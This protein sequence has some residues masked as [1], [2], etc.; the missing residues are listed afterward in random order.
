MPASVLH[1]SCV[2]WRGTG[3]LILGRSGSGKSALALQLIAFG[4]TLVSDDRVQV[5]AKNGT[6]V[7][8]APAQ[9]KG[10][11]EAR[12]VGILRADTVAQTTLTLAVDLDQHAPDRLPDAHVFEL[13]D[14][15]LPCL[16]RVDAPH[17][18]AAVFQAL[19]GGRQEPG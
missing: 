4:A 3:V 16:H 2:D 19:K 11:I 6:L 8:R 10:L 15:A 13:Y 12:G 7:A 14:H 5:T 1:A 18:A 17:F 9:I